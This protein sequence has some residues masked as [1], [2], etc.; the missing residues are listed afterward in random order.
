MKRLNSV[1][2]RRK[3][4]LNDQI[5]SLTEEQ[6]AASQMSKRLKNFKNIQAKTMIDGIGREIDICKQKI[7]K[8][9]QT[10]SD[11]LLNIE[12]IFRKT[13]AELEESSIV[14][15]VVKPEP[16]PVGLSHRLTTPFKQITLP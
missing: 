10:E 6:Q 8:I 15:P 7:K 3:I 12:K 5:M 11:L 4:G 2:N 9:N 13:I 1:I 16:K 14:H